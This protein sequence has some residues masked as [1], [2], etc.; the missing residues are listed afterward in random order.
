[1]GLIG[2]FYFVLESSNLSKATAVVR[3][4]SHLG[5]FISPF[6]TQCVFLAALTKD[7]L[8]SPTWPTNNSA[9][10]PAK[11]THT[12]IHT[13]SR[14]LHAAVIFISAFSPYCATSLLLLLHT[15]TPT[16]F[17]HKPMRH[18]HHKAATHTRPS[19]QR[20][21]RSVRVCYVIARRARCF[22]KSRPGN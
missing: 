5:D 10:L 19:Y 15:H 7:L 17:S 8:A 20:C 21:C 9:T 6:L 3:Y 1:M 13:P 16:L 4:R 22:P 14:H 12:H 2:R 18:I 11:H